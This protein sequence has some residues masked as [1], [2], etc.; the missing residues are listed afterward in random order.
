MCWWTTRTGCYTAMCPRWP[1]PTGSACCWHCVAVGTRAPSLHTRHMRL[2]CCPRWLTLRR[3]RSTR[4][5]ATTWPFSSCASPSSAWPRPTATS[6]RG[7]TAPPSSGAMAHASC[8]AYDH[9]HSRMRWPAATTCALLSSWPTSSTRAR[10]A[11]SP[12]TNTGSAHTRCATRASCAMTWWASSRRWR[13]TR[14][15][16][17]T[18]W[19]S[20]P[21]A[22]LLRQGGLRRTLRVTRPG[23]SS[24]TSVPS[25]SAASLTSIRWT[26]CSLTIPPPPTCG[27]IRD[28]GCRKGL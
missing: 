19:V 23:A 12:S 9:T 22:F 24:R 16:C 26:F 3:L 4:G 20:P 7:H 25:I 2:A 13:M 28:A 8:A 10:A 5:F 18:W 1:A 11:R 17:W 6:W 21:C 15:L 14:P 27:C